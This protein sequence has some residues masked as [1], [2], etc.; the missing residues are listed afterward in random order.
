MF[1][2]TYQGKNEKCEALWRP[3]FLTQFVIDR[4]PKYEAIFRVCPEVGLDVCESEIRMAAF[5]HRMIDNRVAQGLMTKEEATKRFLVNCRR[6]AD[7]P[8]NLPVILKGAT[9]YEQACL[10]LDGE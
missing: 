10:L 9:E 7:M 4:A 3:S 1:L 6:L 8:R 2:I 5:Y